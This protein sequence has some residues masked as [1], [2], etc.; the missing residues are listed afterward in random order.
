MF[1]V[2]SAPSE[3][4]HTTVRRCTEAFRPHPAGQA[5]KASASHEYRTQTGVASQ[6]CRAAGGSPAQRSRCRP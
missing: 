4:R 1:G 5:G 3:P 2:H 6:D